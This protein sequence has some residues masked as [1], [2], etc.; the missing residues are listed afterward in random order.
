[1]ANEEI[2]YKICTNCSGDGLINQGQPPSDVTCNICGGSGYLPMGKISVELLSLISTS[3]ENI[4][5][6]LDK[7]NDIKEK[8]DEIKKVVDGL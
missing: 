8:V 5:D 7:V 4:I 6:I 2:I 1:M 3:N